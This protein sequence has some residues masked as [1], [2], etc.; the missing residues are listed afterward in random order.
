VS[1]VHARVASCLPICHEHVRIEAALPEFPPSVPGQF[2]QVLCRDAGAPATDVLEWHE[3]RLP[4]WAGPDTQQRSAYL[5]RPF[6]LADHWVDAD[7]ATHLCVVSHTVGVGTR[8][9]AQVQVG[10]TLNLTGPLGR[11]FS[12]PADD[13][14]LVLIGGGV[15]IPPLLYLARHLHATGHRDATVIFG[16]RQQNL[17]PVE[18]RPAPARNGTP[19]ECL[20]Y[21]GG[22]R[23]PTTIASDDG[24]VGLRGL[25][26]DA[27][28]QWHDRRRPTGPVT[29]F[30][31]GPEGMLKAIAALTR[32]LG[33]ACQLCIERSMG[34]GL[35][36]CLS[37]I[38]RAR[39]A[40]QP[41]GWRWLLACQDGPVF[42]RDVLLD[43][44][45][46]SA[47]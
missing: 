25:V 28:R 2:V 26:T 20:L 38:V 46:A 17:L 33:L 47:T 35:G 36:T 42:D 23:F 45:P 40:A 1:A 21:P 14:P 13:R 8:W 34:C 30:A 10:D 5:R 18:C 19:T 31:C 27:L 4:K 37:C 43:Y 16:A 12:I 11:G 29:V 44:A 7:G 3:Q 32:E 24:S 15:G 9:L 41:A 6:S 22:A 39:D